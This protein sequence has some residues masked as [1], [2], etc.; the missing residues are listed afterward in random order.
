[1]HKVSRPKV[2]WTEEMDSTIMN[3]RMNGVHKSKIAEALGVSI[4]A[5]DAR[6]FR[7]K[8]QND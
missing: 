2:K 3:A 5:V 6:Y 8:A 4:A 1:M 7:L